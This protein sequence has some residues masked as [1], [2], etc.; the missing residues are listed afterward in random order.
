MRRLVLASLLVL[1]AATAI[2]QSPSQPP[3]LYVHEELAKPSML[4]EYESTT[5]EFG[6]MLR[7]AG[8]PFYFSVSATDD[9]HYYYYLPMTSFG[10]VDKIVQTFM[11]DMPQKIGAEKVTSLM[12]RGGA[13]MELTRD[14]VLVRREDLSYQPTKPR[15]PPDEVTHLK[16]DFYYLKPGMEDMVDTL[17]KEWIS[18]LKAANITDGYTLYQAVIGGELPLVVVVHSGRSV[19]DL[20][21]QATKDNETLG[22]K[23]RALSARTFATVRRYE[24]K[25]ATRRPDLG[26]PAPKVAVK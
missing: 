20:L 17:G 4:A 14:W 23:G 18:T 10:D 8:I 12:R 2:A 11:V 13:T 6:A 16:Y 7:G 26:N 22:E 3:L 5:K 24:T 9:F 19:A 1:T 21:A 25:Y 15:V